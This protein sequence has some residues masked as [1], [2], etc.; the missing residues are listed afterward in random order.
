MVAQGDEL[1]TMCTTAGIKGR[2][3]DKVAE[4]FMWNL[5]TLK[6]EID[7]LKAIKEDANCA[8]KQVSQ[9]LRFL[10]TLIFSMFNILTRTF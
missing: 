8:L 6:T 2:K 9:K 5:S 3:A 10:Y 4:N 1:T 7:I